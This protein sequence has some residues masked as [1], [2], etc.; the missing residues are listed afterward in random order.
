MLRAKENP[1]S[2][3]M[4]MSTTKPVHEIRLGKVK[5]AIWA[6]SSDQG[7][8]HAVSL[9]RL[10]MSDEGWRSSDSFGRDDIPLLIK[11]LVSAYDWI[12]KTGAAEDKDQEQ[13]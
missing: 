9:A 10:Y 11:V 4:P 6:N 1:Q 3:S 7:V 12:F 5:A 2:E 8:W 13:P